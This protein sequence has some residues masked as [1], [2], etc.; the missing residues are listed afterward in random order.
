M[1]VILLVGTIVAWI[2][3][4]L[5][6][7]PYDYGKFLLPWY[8]HIRATGPIG[9]FA[10]PFSNYT[11]PYLYFL[12]AATL[13]PLSPL[14]SIKLLSTLGSLWVVYA[15]YQ[16]LA[17][18]G[19]RGALEG[20][21]AVLL[22]PTII[23]NA[24]VFAQADTFW[25]APSLS[26]IAASCRDDTRSTAFWAGVAFAFKAQ[27]VFIAPFV[28]WMLIERRAPWWHWLLPAL[29]YMIA[30]LPAWLVGWPAF[31]LLSVYVRQAQYVPPNGV[32]FVSTASNW[33]ALFAYLNYDRA[34]EDYW[35][36]FFAAALAA[37]VYVRVL[38]VRRVSRV[39]AAALSATMLPFLL[40]GMHERFY[41]LSELTVFCLAWASRSRRMA[42]AAL[43]M[44]VQLLLAFFGWILRQPVIT[45]TGAG[46]VTAVIWLLIHEVFSEASQGRG[47][48]PVSTAD[49][50]TMNDGTI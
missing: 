29:V 18:T 17:A 34:V 10:H 36:G 7:V 26:A 8:E 47:V 20:S 11:P 46:L 3:P 35:I 21:L 12:A 25:I 45:I 4:F 14:I 6:A 5:T 43:F 1:I 33:W 13:L 37:I 40:P 44:Q 41:A 15:I 22:L 16:V 27:A 42:I 24:P 39:L 28:I 50:A 32:R 38:M 49:A 23:I 48:A 2:G 19:A 31:D 30:V 9:A